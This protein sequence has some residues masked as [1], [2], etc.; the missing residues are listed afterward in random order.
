MRS[1]RLS[2]N[3]RNIELRK[4]NIVFHSALLCGIAILCHSQ[5]SAFADNHNPTQAGICSG[6]KTYLMPDRNRRTVVPITDGHISIPDSIYF[7]GNEDSR[8]SFAVTLS[9]E[10]SGTLKIRNDMTARLVRISHDTVSTVN[11]LAELRGNECRF[12]TEDRIPYGNWQLNIPEGYFEVIPDFVD[13]DEF[14][15]ENEDFEN[16]SVSGAWH[17]KGVKWEG[18]GMFTIHDDD[19]IDGYIP[20]SVPEEYMTTGYYSLLYPILQSLGLRGCISMEGRRVGLTATEPELNDNGKV[21]LRLQN[22]RGWEI[23]SHSMNCIGEVLNNW[24]V[25]SLS[26]SSADEILENFPFSG[27]NQNAT[28]VYDRQTGKQY[29]PLPDNSGWQESPTEYIKPYAGDFATKKAVLYNPDF[30]L[31]WHWG[32]FFRLAS[33]QGFNVNCYACY[34]ASSSHALIPRLNQICPHGFADSPKILYNMPPLMS[35]AMRIGLE[36]QPIKGYTGEEDP[37]NRFNQKHFDFFKKQIDLCRRKGGWIVFYTH[38]YRLCWK[39]HIPG[40]LVS[41]G[42]TYPDEWVH[43]MLGT[44]PLN[45]S[46]DPPARL[47]ISDWSE[48]YPCP[49]TRCEMIWKLF[50]YALDSGMIN[51]TSSEGFKEFGNKKNFGYFSRGTKIGQNSQYIEGTAKS[52]PHFVK[53]ANGEIYYYNPFVSKRITHT[54]KA[55]ASPMPTDLSF[56]PVKPSGLTAVSLTGL[57]YGIKSINDLPKGFWIVNG[58]K[59]II[60]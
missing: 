25:D 33:E 41:E 7:D 47:G 11:L 5:S 46:L 17:L 3:I 34:N 52:Y 43:P 21:A 39:N 30:N 15:C 31:D 56:T 35:T 6:G 36:G 44:D 38:M 59:I 24:V 29:F 1:L 37:D 2:R 49:G 19:C 14:D 10:I 27:I 42:G 13:V 26:S 22:E 40:A 4:S 18:P 57:R 20:S 23:Q 16:F 28:T 58:Q 8:I 51:A 9:E 55:S 54:L 50:K 60:R 45:D 53:G 48:W 12:H 32:R